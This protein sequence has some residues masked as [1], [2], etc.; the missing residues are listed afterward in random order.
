MYEDK[1]LNCKDCGGDF[2]F[3]AESKNSMQKKAFKTSPHAA[4]IAEQLERKQFVLQGKCIALLV[5]SVEGKQL[6]RLNRR[7]TA[8]SFAVNVLLTQ[9]KFPYLGNLNRKT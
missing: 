8:Q 5:R 2:I 3:T 9:N 1:T 6:F 4:R 7:T